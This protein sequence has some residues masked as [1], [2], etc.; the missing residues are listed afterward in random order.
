MAKFGKGIKR[1]KKVQKNTDQVGF[2]PTVSG[3]YKAKVIQAF[4]GI[5]DGGANFLQVEFKLENGGIARAKEYFT[6]GTKKGTKTYYEKDGL[7]YELPGFNWVNNLSLL[8]A[9]ESIL[10]TEWGEKKVKVYDFIKKKEVK[11][12]KHVPVDIVGAKL[13]VGVKVTHQDIPE[14]DGDGNNMYKDN[15]A[16]PSGKFRTLLIVDKMFDIE[17]KATVVEITDDKEPI[18]HEKWMESCAEKEY[19]ETKHKIAS[20]GAEP[21]KASKQG[22]GSSSDTKSLFKKK[23]N[24]NLEGAVEVDEGDDE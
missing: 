22:S 17:N 14:K 2:V 6:S 10:D 20:G 13:Y 18:F 3:I 9:G 21:A 1:S 16:V 19:D 24:R 7:E 8:T 11:Q 23:K 4:A 15:K 12:R 5:S